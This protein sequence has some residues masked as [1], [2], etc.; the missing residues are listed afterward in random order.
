MIGYKTSEKGEHIGGKGVKKRVLEQY[1][2]N[3]SDLAT[4]WLRSGSKKPG[5]ILANSEEKSDDE[6]GSI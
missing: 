3:L 6:S 4:A 2:K 5:D 1:R